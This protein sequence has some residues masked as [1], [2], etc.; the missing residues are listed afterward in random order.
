[1]IGTNE[2]LNTAELYYICLLGK[3]LKEQNITLSLEDADLSEFSGAYKNSIYYTYFS[4][5]TENGYVTNLDLELEV[6][7][8]EIIEELSETFFFESYNNV[9]PYFYEIIDEN[10]YID[11]HDVGGNYK[12]IHLFKENIEESAVIDLTA[13]FHV[14]NLLDGYHRRLFPKLSNTVRISSSGVS[15]LYLLATSEITAGTVEFEVYSN[16][17]KNSL[18]YNAWYFLGREM[19]ML[20]DEGF[21]VTQKREFM[22]SYPND[23]VVGNAVYLY[24]RESTSKSGRKKLKNC[25]IAIIREITE[26][27]ITLEK[28][29]VRTTKLER[30]KKYDNFSSAVQDL[31]RHDTFTANT[32]LETFHLTTIGIEFLMSDDQYYF[33]NYFIVPLSMANTMEMWVEEDG[34]EVKRVLSIPDATFWILK[35]WGIDFDE[36][37]FIKAYYLGDDFPLYYSSTLGN[38]DDSYDYGYEEFEMGQDID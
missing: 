36:S 26:D 5:A 9:E 23:Y 11:M 3:Y 18:K 25:I 22:K 17:D 13:Y 21:T 12:N 35:D 10:Y 4:Y 29:F 16:E 32:H 27:T 6:L 34:F 15:A 7:T 1:M 30:Q 24:E 20:T 38:N 8:D 37:A 2:I 33:E 31:Y 19:G 14:K 28:V